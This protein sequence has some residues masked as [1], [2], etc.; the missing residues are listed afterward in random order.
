MSAKGREYL[1]R[2]GS[3]YVCQQS[4]SF[5][6][7]AVALTKLSVS[8]ISTFSHLSPNPT[9]HDLNLNPFSPLSPD[10]HESV[11]Y[12]DGN[13]AVNGLVELE[14]TRVAKVEELRRRRIGP[15]IYYTRKTLLKI[16]KRCEA[17]GWEAPTGMGGLDTWFGWVRNH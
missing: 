17:K 4:Y 14:S 6:R 1:P 3:A 7:G 10:L 8:P 2:D 5:S 13:D 16:A 15:L 12:S 11:L 9:I